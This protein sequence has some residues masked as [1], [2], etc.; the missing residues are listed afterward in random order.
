MEKSNYFEVGGQYENRKGPYEVVDISDDRMTIRWDSGETRETDIKG[1]L[2][3]IRNMEREFEAAK[4]AKRGHV[5]RFYGELFTGLKECDFSEDVAGTHWR[6]RE[7]LGGAVASHVAADFA[8][9]SWAIYHRPEVHW[10][11][12]ARY[13]KRDAW[14]QAKFAAVA[15]PQKLWVGFYVER[16][17][18]QEADRKDWNRFATWLREGGEDALAQIVA[19]HD[20][21]IRD[22]KGDKDGAFSGTITRENG[23]WIHATDGQST[24]VASLAAFLD[25]VPNDRW[26]D[27]IIKHDFMKDSAI[28][29]G[30]EIKTDIG[31][32]FTALLPVYEAAAGIQ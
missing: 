15:G 31:K 16:S 11:D 19:D 1:Q 21:G 6:S 29:R 2:K 25:E 32:I 8:I 10:A 4:D 26:L 13:P 9:D 7:Q 14:I 17:N 23:C 3:V 18:E 30:A 12:R 20:L 27:L 24:S 5:P 22:Q 28:G